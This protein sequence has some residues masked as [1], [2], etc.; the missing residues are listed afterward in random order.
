MI[1]VFYALQNPA[2]C[3]EY[4]KISRKYFVELLFINDAVSDEKTED[5]LSSAKVSERRVFSQ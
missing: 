3:P 5:R 1:S 2:D 4:P